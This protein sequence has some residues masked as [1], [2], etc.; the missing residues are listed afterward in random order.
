M[1]NIHTASWLSNLCL[2]WRGL[3]SEGDAPAK[4]PT[5]GE[6]DPGTHPGGGCHPGELT[7]TPPHM[8]SHTLLPCPK[9]LARDGTL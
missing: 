5:P 2:A 8:R 9:D 1:C 7:A 6:R 3:W 4:V